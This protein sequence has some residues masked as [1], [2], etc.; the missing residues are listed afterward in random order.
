M[1]KLIPLERI[2]RIIFLIRSKKIMI[3]RD[4]AHMYGV[5]TKVLNQ[6]VRRNEATIL[7]IFPLCLLNKVLQSD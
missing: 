2:E 1:P 3:D 4:L 6:A 5:S 7:N